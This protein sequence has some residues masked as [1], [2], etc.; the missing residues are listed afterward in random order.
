MSVCMCEKCV[1]C[2]TVAAW[3][4]LVNLQVDEEELV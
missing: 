2:C 1:E 3:R 4:R